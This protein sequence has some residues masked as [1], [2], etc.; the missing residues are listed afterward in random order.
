MP[1]DVRCKY[2][3]TYLQTPF[4]MT[5]IFTL[6]IVIFVVFVSACI[7]KTLFCIVHLIGNFFL[8]FLELLQILLWFV[9]LFVCS[10]VITLLFLSLPCWL[11]WSEFVQLTMCSLAWKTFDFLFILECV[12]LLTR[13]WFICLFID[14]ITPTMDIVRIVAVSTLTGVIHILLSLQHVFLSCA[15]IGWLT[16]HDTF[17]IFSE[18][19]TCMQNAALY[20][21]IPLILY[22]LNC[23]KNLLRGLWNPFIPCGICLSGQQCLCFVWAMLFWQ[24]VNELPDLAVKTVSVNCQGLADPQNRIQRDVF[25]CLRKKEIMLYNY[26]EPVWPSGKTG[27]QRDLGSNLLWLSFLFKSCCLWTLSCDFVPHNYETLK[28]LLSLPTL[29]HKSF[30]W[31]QCSDRYIISLSPPP[32]RT[33][34]PS[35]PISNKPYGFCGH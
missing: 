9:C 23:C 15:Y 5:T 7:G 13:Y 25:H 34:S 4:W 17:V 16:N 24:W 29:T 19:F 10:L 8:F 3:D 6:N 30:W 26:S 20:H 27:K 1:T 21:L 2:P 14:Y 18:F 11:C 22:I 35:L 28:W 33:P 31:C 12:Q 32:P